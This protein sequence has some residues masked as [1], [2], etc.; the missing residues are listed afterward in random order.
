MS[1]GTTD[2]SAAPV[3]SLAWR[4]S[5]WSSGRKLHAQL[6]GGMVAVGGDAPHAIEAF[7]LVDADGGLGVPHIDDK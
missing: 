1:W 3:M 4:F 6:V 5:D 7:P 2:A